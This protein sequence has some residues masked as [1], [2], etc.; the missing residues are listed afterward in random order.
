MYDSV[1][2]AVQYQISIDLDKNGIPDV[3]AG[4][5]TTYDTYHWYGTSAFVASLWVTELAVC[6]KLAESFKD[7]DFEQLC[8]AYQKQACESMEKELWTKKDYG[9]Y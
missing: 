1:K 2:K 3:G 6:R 9:D 4:H 7:R 5:G 8:S